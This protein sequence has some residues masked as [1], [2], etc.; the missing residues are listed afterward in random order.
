[1][2]KIS[3][4]ITDS[5]IYSSHP[6]RFKV[7]LLWAVKR[8]DPTFILYREKKSFSKSLAL[9]I[10][11]RFGQKALL[12]TDIKLARRYRFFGVHLPSHLFGHIQRAKRSGLFTV[13]ST[14]TLQEI[15]LA[16]EMG[17]DMVTFSP[18]FTTPNKGK[19]KGKRV[20]RKAVRKSKVPILALGGVVKKKHISHIA[21]T[22][23]AGFA[24]IR[25]FSR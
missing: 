22:K 19:P 14:H 7:R 5:S 8:H 9:W 2:S 3:Y 18:I 15:A 23:A 4:L 13:V 12:H 11:R 20:L 17:A 1:M 10:R 6:T 21:R 16:S 25:Y 24:S